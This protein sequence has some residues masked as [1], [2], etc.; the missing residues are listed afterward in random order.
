MH[1][2]VVIKSCDHHVIHTT[3]DDGNM[4]NMYRS[5]TNPIWIPP[6]HHCSIIHSP[7]HS[8]DAS[9]GCIPQ[10]LILYNTTHLISYENWSVDEHTTDYTMYMYSQVILHLSQVI[11]HLLNPLP[12]FHSNNTHTCNSVCIYILPT[13]SVT[14]IRWYWY[15]SR[16]RGSLEYKTQW[17]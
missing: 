8:I 4:K 13:H 3:H 5:T 14:I 17:Y 6:I 2:N 16:G 11:L 7:L 15:T 9:P 12:L 1:Y 10:T